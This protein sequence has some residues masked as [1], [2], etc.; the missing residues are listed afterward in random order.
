MRPLPISWPMDLEEDKQEE[1]KQETLEEL[2]D[3]NWMESDD[4]DDED[5]VVE[6]EGEFNN[7]EL[8]L[9]NSQHQKM[10]PLGT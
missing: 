4:K 2:L 3:G 6:F 8:P 10:S 9:R 7:N 1:D 5:V